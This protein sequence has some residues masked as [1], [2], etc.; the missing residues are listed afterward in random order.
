[1]PSRP[2]VL[3]IKIAS[4]ATVILGALMLYLVNTANPPMH[5]V[6]SGSLNIFSTLLIV[7]GLFVLIA[8]IRD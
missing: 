7:V 2:I 4:I 6:I 3:L 1:M 5:P 8:R